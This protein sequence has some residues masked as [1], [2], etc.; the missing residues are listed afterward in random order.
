[1]RCLL[2]SFSAAQD[3]IN[4]HEKKREDGNWKKVVIHQPL[5]FGKINALAHNLKSG[6]QG[7]LA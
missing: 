3:D 5:I 4:D 6:R 7:Q 2:V 1:M